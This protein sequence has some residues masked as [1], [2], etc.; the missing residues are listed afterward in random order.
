MEDNFN[1]AL[2][3]ISD[4]SEWGG[5]LNPELAQQLRFVPALAFSAAAVLN[6]APPS[7]H[8]IETDRKYKNQN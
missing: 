2:A 3:F 6:P 4:F 1:V 8:L 5:L 7:L